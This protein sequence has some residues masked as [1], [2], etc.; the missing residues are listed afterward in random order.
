MRVGSPHRNSTLVGD[1]AVSRPAHVSAGAHRLPL[2]IFYGPAEKV[3]PIAGPH[4]TA[5][6]HRVQKRAGNSTYLALRLKLR[7]VKAP[8]QD[9]DYRHTLSST[10]PLA[11]PLRGCSAV[12]DGVGSLN[13]R[14]TT[15]N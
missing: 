5:L 15:L 13:D 11:L 6:L 4:L 8:R 12:Y 2:H 1:P 3:H 10:C 7:S 9:R 14:I